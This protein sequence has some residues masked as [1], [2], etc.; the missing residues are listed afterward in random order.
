MKKVLGL[1]LGTTSIGWALVSQAEN[2]GEK[3]RII[4][5]GVR[6]NPLTTDEKD[7]FNAG[8]DI[9]TN[10]DR[11]L[12]RGARRNLQRYKLRRENLLSL[13]RSLGW[14]DD[15][16][17]LSEDGE[18][19]T[20]STYRLRS[21]AAAEMVS[22]E[23]LARV[24]LMIN[25]KRGYK[26]S[27]KA[28]ASD[29]EDGRLIDGVEIAKVLYEEHL[30]PA[31]HSL[32][33]IEENHLN[34]RRLPDYY[35]SDLK[36]ELDR[37][38]SAQSSFY[39]EILTPD[40]REMIKGKSR[41][42]V[43]KIFRDKFDVLTADNKGKD[44]KIVAL[45]WR[46]SALSERLQPDVLAYVVADIS[47]AISDASGYLGDISDRS[48]FLYFNKLTVGQYLYSE[49]E[50]DPH[51][52]VRNKVFYR[53]DYMDEFERIWETQ[54]LFHPEL[55]EELKHEFRD[56]IIFYQ[57]RL[58]SQKGLI[59][60]CEFES[61]K[62]KKSV[63][64]KEKEI[65]IGC[66]VAPK[67]SPMFQEFKIWSV[68]NNIVVTGPEGDKR[69]LTSEEKTKLSVSLQLY[70]KMSEKEVVAILFGKKAGAILNYRQIEGNDTMSAFFDKYL[71]IAS[72]CGYDS[73]AGRKTAEEKLEALSVCFKQNDFNTDILRFDSSLPKE[74]YEQQSF[75]KLWH[76]LYSY[77]GD[78]SKT[79]NASLIEKI[80]EL[81]GMPEEMASVLAGLT[82]K[83]DYASLSH[84]AIRRILP[85]LKKGYV[86]SEACEM[87]GYRHS[88][89]S[90]TSEE[91]DNRVLVDSLAT[92]PKN[93]LRNP[94]VEKILNQMINVV[95]AIGREYGKPDEI[96]IELARELK[97][98]KDERKQAT[99]AIA[100][101]NAE[102]EK[103]KAELQRDFGL[104]NV[105]RN[106][107]IRYKLYLELKGNGF[108]T[109]YSDRYISQE[110]L[111]SKEI[112]IEHIIPQA[113][114]FD[115][116]LSNKTLEF[117][118]INL[119]KG[120]MTAFD[121]VEKKYGAE[122]LER[123][124][125]KVDDLCK[126]HSISERKRKNLFMT[127]S[128]IPS[129]FI[130]RDLKDSQYIARKAK[131]ILSSYVRIVMSTTGSV[132]K[133]L[134][135]DWRLVNVMQE[136]DMD[137]YDKVGRTYYEERRDGSVEKRIAEWSK[138]DDHRHHA[139]DAITIAF[140]KPSH[141]QLLNNLVAR[142]DKGGAIYGIWIKETHR[143]DSG[144]TFNP[145]MPYDELRAEVKNALEGTLVSHKAKNKV[146]TRNVNRTRKKGGFNEKIELTP[147]G[148]LHKESVYGKLLRY[149]T[150]EVSVNAKM[151]KD[152]IETVS[153]KAERDALMARFHE[154]GDDPKKAFS[155]KNALSKNPI[156][157]DEAHSRQLPPKVK[158]TRLVV[159]YK[160]R[161]TVDQ[162]LT[163]SKVVDTRVRKLL[164]QRVED[165]G[166]D[167]KSAF[168]DLDTN[169]I[170]LNEEKRIPVRTVT[171]SE[172]F[173]PLA[174]HDKRNKDGQLES[175]EIPV[176]FV[177]LK[178]NHHVAIYVDEDCKYQEKVV[179]YFEAVQR[180]LD[181]L[182]PVD[183]TFNASL[184]WKFL[185]SMKI[186]EMFVFPDKETDFVPTEIDL[187][188]PKNY[189][190]VS[191]HLF[192]VQNL[193]NG[194]YSFRHHLETKKIE[195]VKELQ[196][197][198]WKR[199][200][201]LENLR[202]VVKVRINHLGDI[203]A[204]GEE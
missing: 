23:E 86:Y 107:L 2:E 166:G 183:K 31:Q 54:K 64:G 184:G 99:E 8:K 189:S 180:V 21:K 132:T 28:A 127:E 160:L 74:Q 88:K 105:G 165:Y 200:T 47:A 84:K 190:I 188:D 77:E 92:L 133:R 204:V 137:K 41:I 142:S 60:F 156:F 49:L 167:I 193:S 1:D 163:I 161:K 48:K 69:Q 9:T 39:P 96:H 81:S 112:D 197:I 123:F 36:S 27:R 109:L 108:K 22:L 90:L 106:D 126:A 148:A 171:I 57:R 135:E 173:D 130:N 16:T 120:N 201:S 124:R 114:L 53:Q 29:G 121:F 192:R 95:N 136:I 186:N 44:K 85:F 102:N 91:R 191:R 14:I 194:D 111:F 139:M 68:L 181:G 185:F 147:R 78:K 154:N 66:R 150:S 159:S 4:R 56:I 174:L 141:I 61:H 5:A 58:K 149:E 62:I 13:M 177:N 76:L 51:F 3:S 110:Q 11:R 168:Q 73:I 63:G 118:D 82:F 178:N 50:K 143:E 42:Q 146:M 52:R 187:T 59:S 195:N 157:I 45:H 12:K 179:T 152:V 151:T 6:V 83:D 131:E 46:V 35:P 100:K 87:A 19:S 196:N 115:D 158:C 164:E 116:S 70:P 10:A 65:T 101:N 17:V 134:R 37:I 55:T 175:P 26:S 40:F 93:S 155:G 145:P 67:S 32:R 30:T 140:T 94:V 20:F 104:K 25:K 113:K 203:V 122:G 198:S 72:L 125:S 117:R 182:S 89:D 38:W 34:A 176:D 18:G 202:G 103:L 138:R 129:D 33:L 172:N 79:G 75:F 7:G 43:A 80:T 162:N 119:E 144:W 24:F 71:E 170:W 97:Q 128:E 199:I 169:P 15:D 98:S 153:R